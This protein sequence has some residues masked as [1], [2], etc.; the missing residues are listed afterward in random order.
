M[1]EQIAIFS[2]NVLH[3]LISDSKN[4]PVEGFREYPKNNEEF[5]NQ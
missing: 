3:G 5:N 4:N 2:T 1:H